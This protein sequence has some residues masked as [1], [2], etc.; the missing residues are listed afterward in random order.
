MANDASAARPEIPALTVLRFVAL[1]RLYP[2]YL[3]AL[4]IVV[5]LSPSILGEDAFRQVWSSFTW[6]SPRH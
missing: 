5:V 2:F 3:L 1:A 4:L 6:Q